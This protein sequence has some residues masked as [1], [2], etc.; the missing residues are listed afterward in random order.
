MTRRVTSARFNAL[1]RAAIAAGASLLGW[2]Q[3]AAAQDQLTARRLGVLLLGAAQ[4]WE[5][6]RRDLVPALARHGWLEGRNLGINW[7]VVSDVERLPAEAKALVTSGVHVVLTRGTPATRALQAAT[8]TLPIV[9]G[10][11]DPVGSGFAASLASPGGNVTGLSYASAEMAIK[12]L[13]L[14]REMAPSIENVLLVVPAEPTR[15]DFYGDYTSIVVRAAQ[16][17]RVRHQVVAVSTLADLHAALKAASAVERPGALVSSIGAIDPAELA[18][19]WLRARVPAVFDQRGFVELGG[20]MSYRLN[21]D[22]QTGRTA[23]QLDKVLRGT[24]PSQVPFEF[25]T[26]SELV[27]NATTARALGIVIPPA[28]R[29]RAD[30][31][32]E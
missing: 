26:R 21:W 9:T 4:S 1:R 18:R 8:S 11:G 16:L 25:P 6:F 20:L 10:V 3:F 30:A 19:L 28:L 12:E 22:D 24:A 27:I 29:L 17:Q 23:A 32:I 13:E 14:L 15:Q 2:Q 31:V 5:F 7:R